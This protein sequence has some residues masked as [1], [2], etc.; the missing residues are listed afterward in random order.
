M[1]IKLS[2]VVVGLIALYFSANANAVV[3]DFSVYPENTAITDQFAGEG[4]TFRGLEDNVEVPNVT[5]AFSSST[6]DTYLSNCYPTRCV[7]RADVVEVSFTSLADNV[8]WGL[9]SEGSESITFNAYDLNGTLLE[10]VSATSDGGI[11]SFSVNGIKRI[12]MLQPTE[13]WGWGFANLT[14]DASAAATAPVPTM[15]AYGL[16][17]LVLSFLLIVS[18]RL[19]APGKRN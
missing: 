2:L 7:S 19:R 16:M 13:D 14:F 10:T 17:I 1:K 9:D 12:D 3:I 6:G 8:S 11:V 18:T 5:A 15:S 4:V